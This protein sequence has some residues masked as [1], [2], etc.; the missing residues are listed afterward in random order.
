MIDL[1]VK[2]GEWDDKVIKT[3]PL[4]IG[5]PFYI[6]IVGAKHVDTISTDDGFVTYG[7]STKRFSN[8][9]GL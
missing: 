8:Y 3:L 6:M 4:E 9:M 7:I 5:L 2:V 1:R